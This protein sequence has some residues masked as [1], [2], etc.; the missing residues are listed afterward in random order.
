MYGEGNSYTA[1]FWQYAPRTGRRWNIDPVT[2]P[3]TSPYHAFSNR[4]ILNVDP[5]GAF[6][7]KYYDEDGYLVY[8]DHKGN[9]SWIVS[10]C[11]YERFNKQTFGKE[12]RNEEMSRLLKSNGIQAYSSEQEA[13]MSWAPN[14]YK[15]TRSSGME[16]GA[17][18]WRGVMQDGTILYILGTTVVGEPS[19]RLG[20]KQET[21]MSLSLAVVGGVDLSMIQKVINTSMSYGT[22]GMKSISFITNVWKKTAYIHSHPPGSDQFS[23]SYSGSLGG[24]PIGGDVSMTRN[25]YN[26]YL[27]LTTKKSIIE[28]K[29]LPADERKIQFG[30][31]HDAMDYYDEMTEKIIV[32]KNYNNK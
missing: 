17:S 13:A 18:I 8:D 6:D 12:N 29:F 11:D 7:D 28:M 21:N 24:D 1:E 31:V 2:K 32:P 5:N 15:N 14:G 3:W 4:P 16:E 19:K 9:G 25:G 23:A 27:V 20:V 22:L 26:S 30:Y 10:R